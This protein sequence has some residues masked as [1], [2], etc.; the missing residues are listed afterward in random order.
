MTVPPF[1]PGSLT[2]TEFLLAFEQC[3]LPEH[4]RR[5]TLFSPEA[6][7]GFVPPDREPL[8]GVAPEDHTCSAN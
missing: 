2:D 6:R 3:T 8:P 1:Q 5:E 4:Y 7:E